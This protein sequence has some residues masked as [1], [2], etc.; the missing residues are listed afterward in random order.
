MID[1]RILLGEM[2][3]GNESVVSKK[4]RIQDICKKRKKTVSIAKYAPEKK[5]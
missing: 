3:W 4:T 1:L 2:K 5:K